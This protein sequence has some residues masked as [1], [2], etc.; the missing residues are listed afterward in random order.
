MANVSYSTF[1]NVFFYLCASFKN[2][3]NVLK[4]ISLERFFTFIDSSIALKPCIVQQNS[5]FVIFIMQY[6]FVRT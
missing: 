5:F 1:L 3:F 4:K 6:L 2:L